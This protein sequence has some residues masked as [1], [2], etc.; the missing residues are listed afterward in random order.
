MVMIAWSLDLQLPM[1]SV[2]CEFK[3]D[4]WRGVLDTTLCDQFVVDLRQLGG[5]LQ[6]LHISI[7]DLICFITD[8]CSCKRCGK[9]K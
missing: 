4:S 6:V 3:P 1:Q 2:P 7:N 5:S 8:I 9:S